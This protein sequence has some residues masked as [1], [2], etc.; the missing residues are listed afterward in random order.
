MLTLALIIFIIALVLLWQAGRRQNTIGL[1]AGPRV[2][3]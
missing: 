3:S 2:Y 1:P